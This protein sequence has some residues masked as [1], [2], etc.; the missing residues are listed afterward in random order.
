[1]KL[2]GIARKTFGVIVA[3]TLTPGVSANYILSGWAGPVR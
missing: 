1:M 2:W 3:V